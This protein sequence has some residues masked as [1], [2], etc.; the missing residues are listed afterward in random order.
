MR[1]ALTDLFRAK[2]SNQIHDEWIRGVLRNRN[3]ISLAQL[4]RTKELMNANIRDCLVE[5][6]QD[7]IPAI[8][9]GASYIITYNLKDFPAA[10]L[11]KYDLSPQHP[12]EFV[13]NQI[14]LNAAKVC[15]AVRNQRQALRNPPCSQDQLLDIYLR[16]GLV[17]SVAELRKWKH[18]F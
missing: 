13:L 9:S 15:E 7:L 16:S 8:R 6:Y 5:D 1:L 3:D 2:W 4:N 11:A 12:D 18:A 10:E 14:D 17:F